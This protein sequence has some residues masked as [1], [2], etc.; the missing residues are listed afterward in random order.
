MKNKIIKNIIGLICFALVFSIISPSLA[1]AS[2]TQD[3]QINDSFSQEVI[4]E[5]EIV[6]ETDGETD[7]INQDLDGPRINLEDEI[8][9]ESRIAPL[10]PL[11]ATVTIRY[12]VPFL[13]RT[14]SKRIVYVS[15]HAAEQ[16]V[17][18]KITGKMIDDALSNGVKYVDGWSGERIAWLENESEN[19]RTAVLL[20]KGTDEIDTVYNQKSKKLKWLKSTW[21]YVGDK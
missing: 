19:K 11:L 10:I 2:E 12:G 14:A 3:L 5:Q 17:D 18:R 20:K 4:N 21:Q 7:G 6:N 1:K 8:Q 13:A 9:I 15:K 16:A